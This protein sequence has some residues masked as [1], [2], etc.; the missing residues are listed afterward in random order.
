MRDGPSV[1][2]SRRRAAAAGNYT[3]L[4]G[5]ATPIRMDTRTSFS[6]A[7]TRPAPS[8]SATVRAA[9]ARW[10]RPD[11]SS[12]AIAAQLVDY[13]NDGLLD[14]L[15][16]HSAGCDSSQHWRGPGGRRRAIRRSRDGTSERT[17]WTEFA[18]WRSAISTPRRNRHRHSRHDAA[19]C[20]SGETT[21]AA[22]RVTARRLGAQRRE[23]SERG[24]REDR[25]EAGSL[26]D[27]RNLIVDPAVATRRMCSSA[28]VRERRPDAFACCGR[29]AFCG[30]DLARL[31]SRAIAGRSP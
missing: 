31:G 8:P 14:L 21:A 11:G 23:Q 15:T 27:A 18:R 17:T 20:A 19:V 7:Q 16:L 24:W 5:W 29:R 9:F 10:R 1:T 13:D 3:P 2:G 4:A 12:A 25:A 26:A 6:A 30:R 28:S 22:E